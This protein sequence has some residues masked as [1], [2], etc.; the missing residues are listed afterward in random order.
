MRKTH[1]R[2]IPSACAPTYTHTDIS[3]SLI[4][5]CRVLFGLIYHDT[6]LIGSGALQRR[7][8]RHQLTLFTA[9]FRP[10]GMTKVCQ[11]TLSCCSSLCYK[12][13]LQMTR[14]TELRAPSHWAEPDR[15]Y[16][17]DFLNWS[18]VLPHLLSEIPN[19]YFW[20]SPLSLINCQAFCSHNAHMQCVIVTGAGVHF[21]VL[22][23]F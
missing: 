3:S 11:I 13:S 21:A 9:I 1:S 23:H 6:V 18:F 14:K 7:D 2:K 22:R 5:L 4:A 8:E 16:F 17:P 10:V 19:L 20:L 12:T 15:I